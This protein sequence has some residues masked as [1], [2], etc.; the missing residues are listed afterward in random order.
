MNSLTELKQVIDSMESHEDDAVHAFQQQLSIIG[1]QYADK[2]VI[3]VI[4]MMQSVGRYLGSKK[5]NADKDALPVLNFMAIELENLVLDPDLNEEQRDQLLSGCIQ[6]YKSLKSKIASHPLVT[7]TEMQSLK[8]VILAI[9]W[10]ISEIT[11]KTFDQVTSQIL[12][13]IKPHKIPHAFLRIIHSM[14]KYIASKKA[15]AHKDSIFLLRSVFE[16]F[17]RVV[18]TPDMPF[19][20]KKQLIESDIDAFNNFK[21]EIASLKEKIPGPIDKTEDEI[22][23][24]A[25]SHVKASPMPDAQDVVPLTPLSEDSF[26]GQSQSENPAHLTGTKKV[27]PA[28]RD[29]MDDLFSGKESPADE[30]LDAIHLANIQGP[31]QKRAMNM[32]EPTKEDLQKKGIK[33][34]TPH[35]MENE[36]IPEIANRLDEFFNLD[37]SQDSNVTT[38]S[39]N[40]HAPTDGNNHLPSHSSLEAIVPFQFE[41]ESPK[42]NLSEDNLNKDNLNEDNLNEDNFDQDDPTYAVINRLKSI[43]KNHD[44]LL[45]DNSLTTLDKDLSYLKTLW[46]D[47][48][49]KTILLDLIS[50]LLIKNQVPDLPDTKSMVDKSEPVIPKH[51]GKPALSFWGKIKSALFS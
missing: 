27:E 44:G 41:D 2:T 29:I 22:I 25:L 38:T 34:F 11:L 5:D 40:D 26:A 18:Q 15:G 50:W 36:P 33:N 24:P 1:E 42:N 8:A 6:K 35:R 14:G 20:E 10:E 12:T 16:N 39:E 48:Q 51:L 7:T 21:R 23:Q 28:P 43:V 17:E 49:D 9:D 19:Q 32:S 46:Q 45:E 3:S 47:D 13:R 31:D 4:K 37:I 30:L